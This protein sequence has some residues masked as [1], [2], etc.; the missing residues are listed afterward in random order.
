MT[1]FLQH[2]LQSLKVVSSHLLDFL[3]IPVTV[4]LLNIVL[5]FFIIFK[6]ISVVLLSLDKLS[7]SLE[8][9]EDL[10]FSCFINIRHGI[11]ASKM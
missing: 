1:F 8:S 2:V 10:L 9:F 5:L 11:A 6:S 4:H 3:S 7:T